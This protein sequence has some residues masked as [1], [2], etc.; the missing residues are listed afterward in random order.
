M[1]GNMGVFIALVASVA[2]AALAC[3]FFKRCVFAILVRRP[4][5][6]GAFIVARHQRP[7][8]IPVFIAPVIPMRDEEQGY[9]LQS[10]VGHH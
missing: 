2:T 5:R 7:V 1:K 8:R 4:H 6:R 9:E 10:G 3:V